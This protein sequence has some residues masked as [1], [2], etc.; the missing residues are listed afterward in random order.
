[1]VPI[2]S[3]ETIRKFVKGQS[4]LNVKKK[5]INSSFIKTASAQALHY[6]VFHCDPK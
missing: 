5:S 1:M 3:D 2:N 4:T 6:M